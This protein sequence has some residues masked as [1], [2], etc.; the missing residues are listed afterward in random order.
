MVLVWLSGWSGC[1]WP[2]GCLGEPSGPRVT[3]WRKL[4]RLGVAQVL[5]GLVALPAYLSAILLGGLVLNAHNPK[6]V[7]SNPT[8]ATTEALVSDLGL[9][10]SG[11]YRCQADF[12]RRF[13]RAFSR[14][15]ACRWKPGAMRCLEDAGGVGLHA[16]Q[17]VLVGVDRE[18]RGGVPEAFADDLDR[19]AGLDE[20]RAVGVAEVV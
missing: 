14:L 10:G 16:G 17:H 20:Q 8:P 11:F 6:V 4:R 2:T 18:S 12:F 15:L 1:C 19:D 13:N 7:G 3:V 5:D 9:I